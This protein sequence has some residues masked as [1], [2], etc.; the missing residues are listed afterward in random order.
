[1]ARITIEDCLSLGYNKYSLSNL[2]TKRI[3]QLRKGEKPLISTSNEEVVL[4]L[5]EIAAQKIIKVKKNNS[6][7]SEDLFIET[8]NPPEKDSE[9]TYDKQETLEK[10]L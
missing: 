5:R 8:D 9:N 7:Q 6:I 2:V 3:I 10:S 1:M 4:A